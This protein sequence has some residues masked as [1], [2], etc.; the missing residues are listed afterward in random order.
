MNQASIVKLYNTTLQ[1]ITI[2]IR[3][4]YTDG[5]LEE[6]PTCKQYLQVQIEGAREIKRDF[7][8]KYVKNP[9]HP[10]IIVAAMKKK[11]C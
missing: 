11:N 10:L 6:K 2:H 7:I 9:R 5:E 3:K 1:N 4:I 8:K